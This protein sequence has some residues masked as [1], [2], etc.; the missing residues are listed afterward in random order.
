MAW[1]FLLT[2]EGLPL[3]YYGDEIG[4]P[5]Y[6]DPDNRQAMRFDDDVSPDEA[7]VRELVRVLGQA[8]LSHPALWSGTRTPWWQGEADA[9]AYA[10][11][12]GDDAA[13]VVFNRGDSARWFTNGVA[14]AGLPQ[15]VY[16]DVSTG[17][18]FM[19]SGDMLSIEVPA[20]RAR[21]LV[22]E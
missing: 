6:N 20:L 12:A 18:V 3:V 22:H 8:R 2:S 15:G 7:R 10:R 5:G 1:S 19:T 11:V 14:F 16:R 4:L 9:W 17:E 13:L 21:V